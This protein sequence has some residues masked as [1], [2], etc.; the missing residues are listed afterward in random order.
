[1]HVRSTYIYHQLDSKKQRKGK[2]K[3]RTPTLSSITPQSTSMVELP[4]LAM[5]MICTIRIM[6]HTVVNAPSK[7][8]TINPAFLLL[9]IC[10][11]NKMGIGRKKIMQSN[12]IVIA[13]KT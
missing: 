3:G 1:M 4:F 6:L 10:N 8:M 5:V 9:L 2:G 13:A 7:K 11:C 12:I